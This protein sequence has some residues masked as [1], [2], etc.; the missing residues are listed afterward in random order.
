MIKLDTFILSMK[1]TWIKRL[2]TKTPKCVELFEST[3]SNID[4]LINRGNQYIKS[5]QKSI[6]NNFWRDVLEA[7]VLLVKNQDI[8]TSDDIYCSCI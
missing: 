4:K 2:L 5:I 3:V 1:L 8:N 7:W 6:E